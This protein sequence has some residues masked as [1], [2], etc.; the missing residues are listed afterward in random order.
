MT[1]E[2]MALLGY[3]AAAASMQL[4]A[5]TRLLQ[6]VLPLHASYMH[7]HAQTSS[8]QAIAAAPSGSASAHK[9][10]SEQSSSGFSC[11][12]TAAASSQLPSEPSPGDTEQRAFSALGVL[13]NTAPC[14]QQQQLQ[15]QQQQQLRQQRQSLDQANL[16]LRVLAALDQHASVSQP[17][18]PEVVLSCLTLPLLVEVLN[19]AI[20]L[21]QQQQQHRYQQ[22]TLLAED[23]AAAAASREL[24]QPQQHL[25][26][27]ALSLNAGADPL[28]LLLRAAA[29]TARSIARPFSS[30]SSSHPEGL[31]FVCNSSSS[32]RSMA[33]EFVQQ[34]VQ[35]VHLQEC[36]RQ[37]AAHLAAMVSSHRG[38]SCL[39]REALLT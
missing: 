15:Q 6:H 21:I 14:Q 22:H 38:S 29:P 5:E 1:A 31:Q 30:S 3:G 25:F 33:S 28:T 9:D 12:S 11:S 39:P 17:A 8:R 18:Q 36:L 20:T 37:Q 16:L 34:L 19:E 27:G 4:L 13:W 35:G 24:C 26:E 2:L 10:C 7:R 32:S 23:P